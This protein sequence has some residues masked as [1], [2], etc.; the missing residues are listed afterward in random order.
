MKRHWLWLAVFVFFVGCAPSTEEQGSDPNPPL[1]GGQ[2]SSIGFLTSRVARGEHVAVRLADTD[3]VPT[4]ELEVLVGDIP[5]EVVSFNDSVVVFEVPTEEQDLSESAEPVLIEISDGENRAVGEV[6]ILG[7]V[8]PGEVIVL[9]LQGVELEERFE[10]AVQN[11]FEREDG[12]FR[13]LTYTEAYRE[14]NELPE[15]V[16]EVSYEEQLERRRALIEPLEDTEMEERIAENIDLLR[17]ANS[18]CTGDLATLE[19]DGFPLVE[20][21]AAL[22]EVDL[23]GDGISVAGGG[24]GSTNSTEAVNATSIPETLSGQEATIAIL[25]TGVNRMVDRQDAF[26]GRLLENLGYNFVTD[27]RNATSDSSQHGTSVA[28]SAAGFSSPQLRG[29]APAALVLPVKVCDDKVNCRADRVAYGV[30]HA[31]VHAPNGPENLV[32]NLSLGGPLKLVVHELLLRSAVDDVGAVVVTSAG[33]EASLGSPAHYPA[34]L[35][36]PS[37]FDGIIAVGALDDSNG[38]QAWAESTRG[39]FVDLAAPGS[40][41]LTTVKGTSFAAPLV[42]GAAALVRHLSPAEIEEC[43]RQTTQP[44]QAPQDAVGDG[45][46]NV[47]AVL[48][49]CGR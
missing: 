13:G 8:I 21:L 12:L 47:A 26:G 10:Q 24:Q 16:S 35:S 31:L 2:E 20:F 40:S 48:E 49:A 45:M 6:Q 17:G 29:V 11:F 14:R 23:P 38:W 5:A 43:L 39:D 44:P 27:T 37:S 28:F 41:L 1:E 18:L 19:L 34:A 33:N 3:V 25:D 32:I 46:L 42:S 15:Q 4:S 36:S 30:C 7:D 9:A 22:E